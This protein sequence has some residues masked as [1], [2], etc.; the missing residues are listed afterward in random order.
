M[1]RSKRSGLSVD[2]KNLG[3]IAE[4]NLY[5]FSTSY[6]AFISMLSLSRRAIS[7]A[8]DLHVSVLYRSRSEFDLLYIYIYVY[9]AD[10]LS[11]FFEKERGKPSSEENN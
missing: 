6:L 2:E 11:L 8:R 1:Y 4:S 3:S 7:H 9:A 10:F 5:I